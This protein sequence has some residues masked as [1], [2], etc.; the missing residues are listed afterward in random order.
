MLI[1]FSISDH[2]TGG[3]SVP[4]ICDICDNYQHGWI[5]VPDVCDDYQHGMSCVPRYLV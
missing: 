2:P 1:L 3:T 4:D 5:C